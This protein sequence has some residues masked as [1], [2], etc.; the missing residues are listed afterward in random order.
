MVDDYF[1]VD[2][3]FSFGAHVMFNFKIRMVALVITKPICTRPNSMRLLVLITVCSMC[4]SQT[5]LGFRWGNPEIMLLMLGRY[6][7]Q[8]ATTQDSRNQDYRED[9][10]PVIYYSRQ[11]SSVLSLLC[12]SSLWCHPFLFHTNCTYSYVLGT[13]C[14]HSYI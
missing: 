14:T 13:T 12:H 1:L 6:F 10:E 9:S 7:C 2:F 8:R 11:P 3:P 5:V 4:L